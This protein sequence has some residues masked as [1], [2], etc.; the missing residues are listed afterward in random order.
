MS[1]GDMPPLTAS[2]GFGGTGD[3]NSAT[4]ASVVAPS[5]YVRRA[6]PDDIDTIC[7]MFD[8]NFQDEEAV[9]SFEGFHGLE[10]GSLKTPAKRQKLF[11]SLIETCFMSVTV[12]DEDNKIA[13][14]AALDDVPV[15]MMNKQ[16]AGTYWEDWFQASFG[17][18]RVDGMNSLWFSC[19]LVRQEGEVMAEI[20]RATFS[21][22]HDLRYLLV[23]VPAKISEE[24][25]VTLSQVFVSHFQELEAQDT[26]VQTVGDWAPSSETGPPSVLV[27]QRPD[28]ITP[29]FIRTARVEDHDNLV[30]VFDTQSEVVREVYGE[31][32]I[33]ELIEAQNEENKALVAE[34]DGRAVGLM[35][36]TSDVDI[37]VLAQC[38]QLNPYDNLLKPHYMR[39]VREHAQ[40]VLDGETGVS[41]CQ[42]GDYMRVALDSVDMGALLDSIPRQE[43]GRVGAVQLM[44]ALQLQEFPEE[45]GQNIKDFDKGVMTLMWQMNF[46]EHEGGSL[47]DP[48]RL[49]YCIELFVNLDVTARREI[50]QAVID[51][52]AEVMEIFKGCLEDLAKGG[53]EEEEEKVEE[54]PVIEVTI[55]SFLPALTVE[56]GGPFSMEFIAKLAMTLHWWTNED[57][58]SPAGIVPEDVYRASLEEVV[59]SEE[60]L[61]V[62]HPNSPSWLANMPKHAKDVFCVNMCCLDQTY[63]TQALDFLLPAFSLYPEKDYCIITQPHTAANTPLLNAFTIVPPQPQNTFSHVLYCIHRAALLGPPKVRVLTASD[64][65]QVGPLIEG[66]DT[67]TQTDITTRCEAILT[68]GARGGPEESESDEVTSDHAFVAEFDDQVVGLIMIQKPPEDVVQTLRCCYHLDD[69]LLVEHH[70]GFQNKGHGRLVYWVLNPLFSKY[71]RRLKQGAM[72]LGGRTVLFME[73]DLQGPVSP[74]FREFLQVAP[75]RPPQ[76]KKALRKP[77]NTYTFARVEKEEPTKDDLREIDRQR[78]LRDA[79]QT[80]ALSIVAKKL[81]SETKI[82]V[83]ARIVVV[84]AS[85]C[86]LSFLESL[87]SIPHLH[88]NSLTLLAPGGLEYHH[89]HHLPL[90]AGSAAYSHQELRRI[91]LEL[92]V[93]I[94]DSRMVQIDRQQR[95]CILHDRSVLPYDY[96]IVAAGLQDDALHSLKIR[97]WGGPRE[98]EHVTDG[99]RRVN[100]AMSVADPSI[101]DLL[102]EGGTLIKSLIW[103][104]LSY[105]VVYGRSLHAYC[106]VQGLLLRKVPPTKIILVLPPR[107]KDASH[108]LPVDAFQENDEVEQKIHHILQVMEMNVY[109][110]YKLLGIQQDNRE[111]LKALILEEHPHKTR[112]SAPTRASV[113]KPSTEDFSRAR[114]ELTKPHCG[115]LEDFGINANGLRQKLLACRIIITADSVNVDPD[116]FNSVHG[117]GLVYDGRLIVDHNFKTTDDAIF[118]AGRLCEF[119]RRF[120][121][122]NTERYL[123]HDGFNGREVGAKLAQALLRVLDPVNSDVVAAG[124]SS[125]P[126]AVDG[127][128]GEEAGVGDVSKK[129]TE[130]EGEKSANEELSSP[131]LLPEFYMPIAKGGLLPGDLHYYRVHSCRSGEKQDDKELKGDQVIT[132][133]TLDLTNGKGH[134]CR[135]TIDSFGRVDSIT[136]LGGEELQV[137]SLWSLVGLSET[138]LNHLFVRWRDGDIPDIV[139]FLTDEW[140]TALFHDRFM[141]FCYQIKLDMLSQEE[142]KTIVNN[143]LETVNLKEGLSRKLLAQIRSQLPRE[144]VKQMQDHLLKYLRENTNHLKT[145]F[146]P[147]NWDRIDQKAAGHLP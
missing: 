42:V 48:K 115:S 32:F 10:A 9:L 90:I 51:K 61:F 71:A 41:L 147:E 131:D 104:P 99:F 133:D 143:A 17:E 75:R 27:C 102:V 79:S 114:F 87:L 85:D 72:R 55:V 18:D 66:F 63:Q 16:E 65:T 1:A 64:L 82:P 125:R 68:E 98:V 106:V 50:A 113:S 123:R 24:E 92:R 96:L 38:F 37:N 109:D 53:E 112:S 135:L 74:I 122:K 19:C 118:G 83:N 107:L 11:V 20:L 33:A 116:I 52:W 89:A 95:C 49:A 145:Y 6:D 29:L 119:S 2:G 70:Q 126:T 47:V 93:R 23:F 21:T 81:L 100:G 86:G 35:C 13:G 78:N 80:K 137:E 57:I 62:A 54:E 7:A 67:E 132:T 117:N 130:F 5:Y 142:I 31:Y 4:A 73:M 101:R 22:M 40:A 84:G 15:Q 26:E 28:I 124:A 36:L 45:I 128:I 120:Q 97:S 3:V 139:E 144:S 91:M 140:A 56:E 14:F 30:A 34:V 105:V 121:R 44:Q 136:Y 60:G 25:A 110:G 88:F 94:L 46:L 76:L 146:L 43:D 108:Q 39:R 12:E 58:S 8:Q 77:P 127:G 134:Y 129:S 103:N 69:Y 59:N 138:F 111:R 141:D